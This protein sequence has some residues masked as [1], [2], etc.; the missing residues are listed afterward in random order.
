MGMEPPVGMGPSTFER[1]DEK[2]RTTLDVLADIS[3][4]VKRLVEVQ[5]DYRGGNWS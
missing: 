2:M 4:V 3:F 1:T 5:K